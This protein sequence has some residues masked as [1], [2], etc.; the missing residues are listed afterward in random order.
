MWVYLRGAFSLPT[1]GVLLCPCGLPGSGLGERVDVGGYHGAAVIP[2]HH[3]A[4]DVFGRSPSVLLLGTTVPPNSKNK[5][6]LL[7]VL[8]SDPI[9]NKISQLGSGS[10]IALGTTGWR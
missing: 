7:F 4:R 5:G 2:Y 1:I 6:G 3:A 8:V 9:D 10:V